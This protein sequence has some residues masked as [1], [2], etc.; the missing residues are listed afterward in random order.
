MELES[1][2][3]LLVSGEASLPH[4]LHPVLTLVHRD[5]TPDYFLCANTVSP[6]FQCVPP[7]LGPHVYPTA[8]HEAWWAWAL[9]S[10]RGLSTQ[11]AE[12]TPHLSSHE[13]M[14]GLKKKTAS[15]CSNWQRPTGFMGLVKEGHRAGFWS[16]W[17]WRRG[18]VC[19]GF[20]MRW[21]LLVDRRGKPELRQHWNGRRRKRWV[22]G[23]FFFNVIPHTSE[24][25]KI[26][27]YPFKSPGP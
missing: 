27:G 12:E 19:A 10:E 11:H 24:F 9:E 6:T 18:S 21:S 14:V 1:T 2:L 7:V 23:F 25:L 8:N 4:P 17:G 13:T 3:H 22:E 26:S 16:L 5:P 20:G 15:C